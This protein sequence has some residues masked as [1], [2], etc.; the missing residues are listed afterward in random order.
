M[1]SAIVRVEPF[2]TTASCG[3]LRLAHDACATLS[4]RTI[5]LSHRGV[6]HSV[7]T[8]AA[9]TKSARQEEGGPLVRSLLP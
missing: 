1:T 3:S 6:T 2:A 8:A 5:G 9:A 4:H 7:P